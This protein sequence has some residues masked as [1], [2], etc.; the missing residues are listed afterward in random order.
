MSS[1][2]RATQATLD[3]ERGSERYAMMRVGNWS[4]VEARRWIATVS[5]CC[6]WRARSGK[7]DDDGLAQLKLTWW[8]FWMSQQQLAAATRAGARRAHEKRHKGGGRAAVKQMNYLLLC[9]H[10][11]WLNLLLPSFSPKTSKQL[12]PHLKPK[13]LIYMRSTTLIKDPNSKTQRIKRTRERGVL[14]KEVHWNILF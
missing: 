3:A 9:W 1:D 11:S 12:N 13:L 6:W 10:C 2:V 5:R 4:G 8:C 14:W 7:E